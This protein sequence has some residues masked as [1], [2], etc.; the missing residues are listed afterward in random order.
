MKGEVKDG[1]KIRRL[2]GFKYYSGQNTGLLLFTCMHIYMQDFPGGFMVKN[3]PT[4]QEPQIQSLG[5]PPGEENGNPLQYS[6]L[7]NSTDKGTWQAGVHGV[8]KSW[9]QLSDSHTHTHTHT[10]ACIPTWNYIYHKLYTE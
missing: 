3:L 9:T 2:T 8:A 10:Y 6:C 4:V 1:M 5:R 7:E